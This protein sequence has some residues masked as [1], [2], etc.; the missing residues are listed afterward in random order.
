MNRSSNRT[1]AATLI[2]SHA[3]LRRASRTTQHHAGLIVLAIAGAGLS[4]NARAQFAPDD[5]ASTGSQFTIGVGA[6]YVPRYEGADDYKARALPLISYRSGRFFAGALGGIGYDFST[7]PDLQ[8]GPVVSYRFGRD[9][10]DS[11]RLRGLG[12]IDSGADVGAFVRWNIRPFFVHATVRQGVGGDVTGTQLRLGAGYG[13]AIGPS[14]RVVLDAS[15]DWA[16]RE[17]MQA[18]F[19]VTGAQSARSGLR[20]YN[21]DSGIRRYGVGALWTHSFTPQWFSTVGVAAYR[22]GSEAA[23]S[24]ITVDRNAGL[25]SFGVGYRF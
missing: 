14:D 5:Q 24:P 2:A 7:V 15:V 6:A 13:L 11:D 18:Y 4:A 25:V 20:A 9:E 3:L 17:V 21:A 12:D 1:T 16:D 8:F 19:G 10:S 23:D 22:L